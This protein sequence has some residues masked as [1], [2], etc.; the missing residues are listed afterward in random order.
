MLIDVVKTKNGDS[1]E[2]FNIYKCDSCN[3]ELP[4]NFPRRN[5]GESD[6]CGECAFKLN[7]IS[8]KEYIKHFAFYIR[9][10]NLR[11]GINPNTNEIEV[12]TSKFS[13]EHIK[14]ERNTPQYIKWRV[15]VFE[16]D[17]FTCCICHQRGGYLEAHH[18][19]PF[20]KYKSER[21]NI[22]NGV[23]LCKK[24]HKQVHKEGNNEWLYSD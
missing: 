23:T 21:L 12:T 4:E 7:K 9:L 18:I 6:Y 3:K 14:Q 19:K 8:D 1:Y 2:K 20:K 24:C 11:A 10:P 16:R 15:M 13:W 22:D 17:N 5:E